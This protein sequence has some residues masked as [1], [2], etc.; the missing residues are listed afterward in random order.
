MWTLDVQSFYTSIPHQV[1]LDALHLW[2]GIGDKHHSIF[3]ISITELTGQVLKNVFWQLLVTAA[4]SSRGPLFP[5][6][7]DILWVILKK[8]WFMAQRR[9]AANHPSIWSIYTWMIV[10]LFG[11]PP[12]E[13]LIVSENI[14]MEYIGNLNLP[15]DMNSSPLTFLDIYI[16]KTLSRLSVTSL[17]RKLFSKNCFMLQVTTI[18]YWSKYPK[19]QVLHTKQ[20][21]S[22]TDE[23][24]RFS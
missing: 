13:N 3:N 2:L 5:M 8:G 7:I 10:C 14:L 20:I 17:H 4:E 21:C 15:L 6:H 23:Y 11:S 18:S 19:L 24:K 9:I 12:L 22:E 1:G 16:A